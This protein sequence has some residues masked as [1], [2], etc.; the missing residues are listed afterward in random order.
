MI[1]EALDTLITLGW[2]FLAW[3][4]ILA[5]ATTAALYTVAVTLIAT[6]RAV[7]RASRALL[8]LARTRRRPRPSWA[9]TRRAARTL[10]RYNE[11]A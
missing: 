7:R 2:T 4:L 10:T 9:L 8:R 5:A 6:V 1:A 3:L 11:A